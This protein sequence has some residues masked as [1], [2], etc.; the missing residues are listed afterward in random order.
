MVFLRFTSLLILMI[1]M[2]FQIGCGGAV[3]SVPKLD[4]GAIA[5]AA[6]EEY[7][8]NKDGMIDKEELKKSPSLKDGEKMIDTNKDGKLSQD[9]IADRIRAHIKPGIALMSFGCIVMRAGEPVN[10]ANVEMVPEKFMGDAV[11][12]AKGRTN[13]NGQVHFR[14]PGM[15]VDGVPPG[16]YIIKVTRDGKPSIPA[17]YNENTILGREIALDRM[18]RGGDTMTIQ[19]TAK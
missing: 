18:G 7:D 6:L 2:S 10:E 14:A 11:K 3:V 17:R 1:L 8:A 9:E 19:I 5:R 4:A 13:A 12:S 15:E 16:F